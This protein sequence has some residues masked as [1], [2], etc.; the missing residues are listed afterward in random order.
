MMQL[1][2]PLH[3]LGPSPRGLKPQQHLG[4]P[5]VCCGADFLAFPLSNTLTL[6]P[7]A[8]PSFPVF[9]AL[10]FLL[11]VCLYAGVLSPQAPSRSST[12]DLCDLAGHHDSDLV[13]FQGASP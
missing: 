5:G 11:S 10:P 1:L 8:F 7:S 9:I 13:L 3:S 2:Q 12:A 6:T 4:L